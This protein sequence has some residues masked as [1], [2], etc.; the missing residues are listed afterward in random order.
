MP[1]GTRLES[2]RIRGI[3][4]LVRVEERL[5]DLQSIAYHR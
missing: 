4:A 5:K 1:L 3:S 2:E